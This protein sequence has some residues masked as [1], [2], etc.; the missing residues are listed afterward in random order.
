MKKALKY[1]TT[2]KKCKCPYIGKSHKNSTRTIEA[3]KKIKVRVKLLFPTVHS[4]RWHRM[5]T[6]SIKVA[7][8]VAGQR[9]SLGWHVCMTWGGIVWKEPTGLSIPGDRA[10]TLLRIWLR[11]LWRVIMGNGEIKWSPDQWQ[12]SRW[13]PSQETHGVTDKPW[14]LF[15]QWGLRE[16]GHQTDNSP[17]GASSDSLWNKSMMAGTSAN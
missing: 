15:S 17:H 14:D 6:V 5:S 1:V 2:Y 8:S 9:A 4:G 13:H 11:S 3:F 7:A 12:Q 10:G 16:L